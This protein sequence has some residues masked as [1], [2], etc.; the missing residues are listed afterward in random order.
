MCKWIMKILEDLLQI[1][2]VS[3]EMVPKY[4]SLTLYGLL[5]L[6][7][8]IF[9]MED[10]GMGEVLLYTVFAMSLMFTL[11]LFYHTAPCIHWK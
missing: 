10:V 6:E 1:I 2:L 4:V 5:P 9:W 7:S 11:V 8:S 3:V